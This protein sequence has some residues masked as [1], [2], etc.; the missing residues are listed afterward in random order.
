M[1]KPKR[2][3]HENNDEIAVAEREEFAP[4]SFSSDAPAMTYDQEDLLAESVS[5]S[6][7]E[8]SD[9]TANLDAQADEAETN[10]VESQSN[11]DETA[12]AAH[13]EAKKRTRSASFHPLSTLYMCEPDPDD[14]GP[15]PGTSGANSLEI[16]RQ[17][18]GLEYRRFLENGGSTVDLRKHLARGRVHMES[19]DPETAKIFDEQKKLE[20]A[21][22][23]AAREPEYNE[24]AEARAIKK[25]AKA[26]ARALKAE[27]RAYA[28]ALKAEA[29]ERIKVVSNSSKIEEA[30][31]LKN[32]AIQEAEAIRQA[33]RDTAEA[34]K[35][36]ARN[37]AGNLLPQTKN[38]D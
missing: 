23:K 17:N 21:E 29:R 35:Q 15:R 11:A 8:S 33:A 19:P 38:P 7:L 30:I 25:A 16:I 1:S 2:K 28:R 14:S 31:A 37:A 4:P 32:A 18:D 5:E 24:K 6:N 27:A 9:E 36:A 20:R 10:N 3:H 34:I 22:L 13:D 12:D 26:E